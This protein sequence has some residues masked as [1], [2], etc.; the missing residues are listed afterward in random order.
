M[1]KNI[2]SIIIIIV[3]GLLLTLAF[4]KYYRPFDTVVIH[5]PDSA[6][7]QI[8]GMNTPGVYKFELRVMDD[9][10]VW[11]EPDTVNITVL[12]VLLPV[13]F[14]AFTGKAYQGYNQLDWIVDG[15]QHCNRY[16]ILYSPDGTTY[17]VLA[18][19]PC[20]NTQ[21]VIKYSYYHYNPQGICYY[22]IQ[23]IDDD[24]KSVYSNVIQVKSVISITSLWKGN[25][26]VITTPVLSKCL[27]E[28]YQ[29]DGKL[30]VKDQFSCYPGVTNKPVYLTK[31]MYFSRVTI[32]D[33]YVK[34][35]KFYLQ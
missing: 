13:N 18:H 31:G 34:G 20:K 21:D 9:D 7:T 3:G 25:T 15:E 29:A 32:N 27:L 12:P 35:D 17:R 23:Q 30:L 4:T 11:S 26:L 33:T 10:S 2:L 22:K 16:D 14:R 19:T 8:S 6:T 24:G 28:I 5:S 1:I